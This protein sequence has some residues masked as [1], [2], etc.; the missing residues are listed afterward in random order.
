MDEF[1]FIDSIKPDSY[2]QSSLIKGI[3]D[4]AAVFRQNTQDIVTAVDTMVDG[5]HFSRETMEPYS[6]GYRALAANL[7]DLAAMGAEPAFFMVSIVIPSD[8]A[9]QEL[10]EVYRG[11]ASLGDG[12]RMDMIGGDTVSGKEFAISITVFGYVERNKA[13][14]RTAAL[15]GDILFVTGTLGDSRAGLECINKKIDNEYLIQRHCQPSPR[16]TFAEQLSSFNR[17]A[18]NDVSDGIA[19]EGSEIAEASCVDLHIAYDSIPYHSSIAELFPNQYQEWILSGGEDFELLGTISER[20]WPEVQQ[21]AEELNLSVTKIGY[22]SEARESK[23]LVYLTMDGRTERLE[24][25]GYTHL[26]EG[27]D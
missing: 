23:G 3:D 2:R 27:R 15:P 16:I 4:D 5:I 7:S 19:S 17:V 24:K 9:E 11:M 1:S 8:W 25:S 21:K 12:Y 26:Q 6:I 13:R 10:Q 20:E 22:V 14:Y 18:L